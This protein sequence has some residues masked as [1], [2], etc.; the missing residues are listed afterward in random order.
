MVGIPYFYSYV[1]DN[2]NDILAWNHFKIFYDLFIQSADT[3]SLGQLYS[4]VCLFVKHFIYHL[5]W[6]DID[7]LGWIA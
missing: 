5:S 1:C 2:T 7:L 6:C 4:S 3:L